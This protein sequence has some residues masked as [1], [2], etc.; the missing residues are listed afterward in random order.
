MVEL[1]IRGEPLYMGI[2]SLPLLVMVILSLQPY[3]GIIP[4]RFFNKDEATRR[5]NI[6]S[7]GLFALIFGILTQLLGL[8]GALESI[9]VW[10]AV[11]AEVLYEGLWVSAIP[12]F[13]GAIIFGIGL[14]L[15]KPM[16]KPATS[17]Q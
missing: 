5:K 9:R 16:W 7:I 13:Y 17:V 14:L 2:L 11:E 8:Y 3:H 4:S 12:L 6:R 10:G 15:S 1:F